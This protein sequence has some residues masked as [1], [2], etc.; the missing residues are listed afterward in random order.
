MHNSEIEKGKRSVLIPPVVAASY[1]IPSLEN[2]FWTLSKIVNPSSILN[3]CNKTSTIPREEPKICWIVQWILSLDKIKPVKQDNTIKS[4]I[5]GT[6]THSAS[7]TVKPVITTVPRIRKNESHPCA[8]EYAFNSWP[9]V[10][11]ED[12]YPDL[13]KACLSLLMFNM[14]TLYYIC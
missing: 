5:P 6:G 4:M 14:L 13:K 12:P 10:L 2:I 1:H 7:I 11:L 3:T 9:I 8:G